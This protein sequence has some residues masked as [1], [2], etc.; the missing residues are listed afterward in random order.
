MEILIFLVLIFAVFLYVM[1]R[2]AIEEK[3]QKKK[4][5]E[6]MKTLYGSFQDRIYSVEEINKIARYYFHRQKEND[7]DEI[8]WND[9]SMD[10]IFA[11]VNFTQSSSGE[12]YLYA[13]LRQ[14]FMNDNDGTKSKMEK[15]I[16]YMKTLDLIPLCFLGNLDIQANIPF[17]II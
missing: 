7:I 16:Q 3:N 11:R 6:Q 4:Y 15:H 9:L 12:E 14:P 17:L 5:R 2:G 10:N 1:I 8:T 13:M